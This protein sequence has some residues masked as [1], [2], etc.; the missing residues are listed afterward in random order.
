MIEAVAAQHARSASPLAGEVG[1]QS[2]AWRSDGGRVRGSSSGGFA[3]RPFTSLLPHLRLLAPEASRVDNI[4]ALYAWKFACN[5]LC[6]AP[7]T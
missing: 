2:L 5:G 3:S 6:L 1:R 4:K 7:V